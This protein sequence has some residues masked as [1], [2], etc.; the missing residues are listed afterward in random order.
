MGWFADTSWWPLSLNMMLRLGGFFLGLLTGWVLWFRRRPR[1]SSSVTAPVPASRLLSA[2]GSQ[3]DSQLLML[4]EHLGWR[5]QRIAV[6]EQEKRI[7]LDQLAQ[8]E[9]ELCSQAERIDELE[10]AVVEDAANRGETPAVELELLRTRLADLQ[11]RLRNREHEIR[12]K[13]GLLSDLQLTTQ[14]SGGAVVCL[15]PRQPP[16]L[17]AELDDGRD[18]QP[19]IWDD[20]SGEVSCVSTDAALP[21]TV[22]VPSQPAQTQG[23]A[24]PAGQR[25]DAAVGLPQPPPPRGGSAAEIASRIKA[26]V[27]PAAAGRDPET[28]QPRTAASA[29]RPS[30]LEPPIHWHSLS[31]LLV[32]PDDGGQRRAPQ[33][34]ARVQ[35]RVQ[36]QPQ[37]GV[38]SLAPSKS[39]G[40]AAADPLNARLAQLEAKRDLSYRDDLQC[41][42]G[43]GPK[44]ESLL[45][46]H[47]VQTFYQ[48]ALL[49]E[50]AVQVLEGHLDGMAGR[51]R[52]ENWL[53]QAAQCHLEAHGESL[54]DQV[55]VEGT[56]ADAFERCMSM[57]A[58]GHRIDYVDDLKLIKG[59]GP[60]LENMLNE[61]GLTTFVQVSMLDEA[62]IDALNARL[63]GFQGRIQRDNWVDQAA[64]LYRL[65]H[66]ADGAGRSHSKA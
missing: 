40:S 21:A 51:I 6:L 39:R 1:T 4:R 47:G 59:V 26:P 13:D 49:D 11:R 60:K 10:G 57:V 23:Q 44:A 12:V 62:A 22:A 3:A 18:S 8:L 48:L 54:F 41:I 27:A 17:V 50:A 61:Q 7:A 5:E 64:K 55:T 34:Q 31:D 29:R 65:Y 66:P 38:R 2:G 25:A 9:F 36:A 46:R 53:D 30:H 32:E 56:Y 19:P 58:R 15:L 16:S 52:R 20:V 24:A 42:R 37:T 33:M 63:T 43:V 35:A 45:R 28:A 14:Q